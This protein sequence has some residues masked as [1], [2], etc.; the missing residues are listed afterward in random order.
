ME[1][2]SAITKTKNM[3]SVR[4][5]LIN[6]ETFFESKNK[7]L[8]TLIFVKIFAFPTKEFMLPVVASLK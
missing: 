1:M 6:E 4:P 2:P 5:K 7:Y 8:G 3:Q